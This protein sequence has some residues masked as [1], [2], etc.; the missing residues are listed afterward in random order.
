MS[1]IRRTLLEYKN[2][3]ADT[4]SVL[5]IFLGGASALNGPRVYSEFFF[6]L[7]GVLLLCLLSVYVLE[8]F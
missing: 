8:R 3:S 5:Q 6:E 7:L 4:R 2:K 1:Q